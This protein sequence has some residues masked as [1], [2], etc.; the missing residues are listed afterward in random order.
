MRNMQPHH[1]LVVKGVKL[2]HEDAEVVII[3]GMV[4]D[5]HATPSIAAKPGTTTPGKVYYV[6]GGVARNVAECMSKLGAKPYMI[7][8]L[9]FDMAGNLL[10]EKWKSTGLS[11]EVG[12][13]KDKVIDTPVVCNI[14]DVNGE[15]AAGVA[16]VQAIEK[17]LTPDWILHFKSTL[18][19]APVLMVDANL[20]PPSLEASCK[21]AA[22]AEC[23]VW[24]EP[25]SVT[26]SRRISSV[27]E[28]VTFASPNEVELIAMAN[29][30]SGSEESHPLKEYHKENNQSPAS[31]FQIL[32]PAICV[33]LEKGIKVVLVTLGSNGVFLCSKGGPNCIKIPVEKTRQHGFGG[34]LYRTVMQRFPP[35]SY[36]FSEH[37]RSSRL[38][39]LHLPSVPASVVRLTG[40]GDCLVGGTLTSIS[41]GLDIIQSVSVGIAVAKAA[42]EAE[43][44]VPSAFSLATIAGKVL[45][46]YV[47]TAIFMHMSNCF[48][49]CMFKTWRV[50]NL[51]MEL[52]YLGWKLCKKYSQNFIMCTLA[53]N[54]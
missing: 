51:F 5:I 29:A 16:S 2:E 23:P 48:I 33:L 9:G 14:F 21:L 53:F 39:A 6:Q 20:S 8:A 43:A 41:A 30:L 46:V 34:E 24:F 18:L 40:A 36:S 35:S 4:L 44:N 50:N 22:D 26:K 11:I 31:S 19:S 1:P 47:D 10:L 13:L 28:Y 45:L 37:G 17:Y 42:V 15:V 38:F 49:C 52:N 25:V 7:S 32:K 27:A 12:I 3:G 54:F